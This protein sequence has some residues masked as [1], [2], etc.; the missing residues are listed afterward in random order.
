M[1]F[2]SVPF[3]HLTPNLQTAGTALY[4]LRMVCGHY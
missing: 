3:T 2:V 1:E 4:A